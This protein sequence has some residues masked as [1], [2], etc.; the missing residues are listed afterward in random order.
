MDCEILDFALLENV[1]QTVQST[2]ASPCLFLWRR[3]GWFIWECQ[4]RCL[5]LATVN[6]HTGREGLFCCKFQRKAQYEKYLGVLI[7]CC[8][9]WRRD[10]G[11]RWWVGTTL[12]RVAG[13]GHK[14]HSCW[15]QKWWTVRQV[16]GARGSQES[17]QGGTWFLNQIS[18]SSPAKISQ[19]P[20]IFQK[21]TKAQRANLLLFFL[22]ALYG[23]INK[24][25][26]H[27]RMPS[28]YWVLVF[29]LRLKKLHYNE[30]GIP[31]FYRE[32]KSCLKGVF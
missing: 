16:T 22:L 8:F 25:L 4:N 1:C 24:L 23:D 11:Y 30:Q 3:D 14:S 27:L 17:M 21:Q 6:K 15:T 2:S 18:L 19:P 26:F 29:Y 13:S 9:R 31:V 7:W 32:G 10:G 12:W 5:G 28:F 20:H